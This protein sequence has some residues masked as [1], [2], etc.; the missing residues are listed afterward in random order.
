ME[1]L[2]NYSF[3]LKNLVLNWD[4][5][6]LPSYTVAHVDSIRFMLFSNF[7]KQVHSI[8]FFFSEQNTTGKTDQGNQ[9]KKN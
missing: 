9:G 6:L 3:D 8:C 7:V 5:M 4:M 1:W 2:A